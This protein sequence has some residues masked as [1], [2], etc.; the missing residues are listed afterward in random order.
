MH[1]FMI[2]DRI[3]FPVVH[4]GIYTGGFLQPQYWLTSLPVHFMI[5]KDSLTSF[6][7]NARPSM[8]VSLRIIISLLSL[9]L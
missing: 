3:Q 2:K 8:Q 4:K 7:F 1:S 6:T 9:S 5:I